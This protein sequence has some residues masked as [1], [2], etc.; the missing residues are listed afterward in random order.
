MLEKKTTL[1]KVP[2]NSGLICLTTILKNKTENNR[3][4]KPCLKL[5]LFLRFVGSIYLSKSKSVYEG[6]RCYVNENFK[7]LLQL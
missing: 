3:Y 2:N 5:F 1:K 6:S 4:P 7:K